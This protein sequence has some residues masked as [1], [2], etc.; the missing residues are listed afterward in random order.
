MTKNLVYYTVNTNNL[1]ACGLQWNLDICIFGHKY[2]NLNNLNLKQEHFRLQRKT[3]KVYRSLNKYASYGVMP[4][5]HMSLRCRIPWVLG[6]NRKTVQWLQSVSDFLSV[7][8]GPTA[9]WQHKTTL[10]E[11]SSAAAT[12]LPAAPELLHI[13]IT[14]LQLSITFPVTDSMNWVFFFSACFSE[15][16]N[17]ELWPFSPLHLNCLTS[18]YH[19]QG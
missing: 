5:S 13:R 4:L 15:V 3:T 11:P 17:R 14:W 6:K 9:S 12:L 16:Y 10:T 7:S 8:T 18:L 1:Q 2:L 19:G